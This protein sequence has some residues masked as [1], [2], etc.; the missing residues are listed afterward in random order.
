VV[1]LRAHRRDPGS[2]WA[3]ATG[4]ALLAV[5]LMPIQYRAGAAYPHGHA[6]IQ[7]IHESRAGI[8]VHQHGLTS[9]EPSHRGAGVATSQSGTTV[10]QITAASAL[11]PLALIALAPRPQRCPIRR[12]SDAMP[13]SRS[14]D[15][16]HP[17]PRSSAPQTASS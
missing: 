2:W 4:L 10:I 7:L 3:P 8:P 17:P 1:G 14:L 15:P 11:L 9:G 6:L 5:L 13:A 12:T 16:G